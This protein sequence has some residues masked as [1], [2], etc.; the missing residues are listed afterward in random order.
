MTMQ[1][2]PITAEMNAASVLVAA[3]VGKGKGK[4][5]NGEREVQGK[6]TLSITHRGFARCVPSSGRPQLLL[7]PEVPSQHGLP[8]RAHGAG[9]AF[10]PD[11]DAIY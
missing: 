7:T 8:S 11:P 10:R 9:R 5:K 2:N 6:P 1:A 3:G 4:G